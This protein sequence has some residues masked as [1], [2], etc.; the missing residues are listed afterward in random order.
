MAFASIL[1]IV[2]I[3]IVAG[4]II[5]FVAHMIIGAFDN[6]RKVQNTQN[7]Q[8]LEYTQYKQLNSAEANKEYDFEAINEAK[9]EKEEALANADKE[10]EFSL[11][12]EDEDKDI[13]KIENEL[14]EKKEEEPAQEEDVDLVGILDEISDEVVEDESTKV[15]EVKMDDELQ[16][17]SIDDL[18]KEAE[19]PEEEEE[20]EEVKAEEPKEEVKEE[21][22]AEEV[23]PVEVV[24]VEEVKPVISTSE[25]ECLDR[26][27]VLDERLKKAKRE[28]RINQKEYRPL[29]KMMSTLERDQAKLRRREALV[30]KQKIDLYGV[31]NYVDIDKEKAEKLANELEFLD[32]LRLS[33]QHC[34]DVVNANKDRFPIL[35]RTN[36]ILEEQISHIEADIETTKATLQ[37]IREQNGEGDKGNK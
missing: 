15:E 28:F 9:A 26:L 6:D 24:K 2:A 13:A 25:Q 37:K 34:E 23:K 35:E 5:A 21:P 11:A 36:N 8:S 1:A 12:D 4:G 18:L 10:D 3:V 27:A 20:T 7:T 30:A 17:Y 14:K 29:K 22:K 33:V 19:E 32:G 31:N 16:S